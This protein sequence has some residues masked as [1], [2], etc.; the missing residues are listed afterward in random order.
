[1]RELDESCLMLQYGET[2]NVYNQRSDPMAQK[3][4][5]MQQKL[6]NT[7]EGVENCGLNLP[8]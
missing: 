6:I 5:K 4:V 7:T 3:A 8:L 1:M 2:Q